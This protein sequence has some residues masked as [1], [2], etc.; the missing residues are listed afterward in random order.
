MDVHTGCARNSEMTINPE[1]LKRIAAAREMVRNQPPLSDDE[2]A[3]L[4]AAA[5]SDPDNPP[6]TEDWFRDAKPMSDERLAR[7]QGMRRVKR[8]PVTE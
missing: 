3:E 8:T 4:T 2:D 7:Y 5:L 1:R 6:L